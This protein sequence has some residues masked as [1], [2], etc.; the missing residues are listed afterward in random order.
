VMLSAIIN[1]SFDIG[2]QKGSA[3]ASPGVEAR[4]GQRPLHALEV[5]PEFLHAIFGAQVDLNRGNLDSRQLGGQPRYLE[6]LPTT[7]MSY[8]RSA[9]C[10]ASSRPIPAD[11]PVTRAKWFTASACHAASACAHR[12]LV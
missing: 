2:I 11:A 4:H 3:E 10:V 5:V 12:H 8:A 7:T 1:F 9:S 6:L